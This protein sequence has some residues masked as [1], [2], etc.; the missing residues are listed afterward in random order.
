MQ[1]WKAIPE[2]EG[3]YEV[4]NLGQV[5]SLHRMHSSP[6]GLIL[7]QTAD[8]KGYLFVTLC[9]DG[10]SR[11]QAVHRLVL[12]AFQGEPKPGQETRHLNG[13]PKDNR[14][15]NLAWGSR[16]ENRADTT[17][18]GRDPHAN[19]TRC[20][21]GHLLFPENTVRKRPPGWRSCLACNRAAGYAHKRKIPLTKDLADS[22]YHQILEANPTALGRFFVAQNE[23]TTP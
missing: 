20:I 12:L 8:R 3:F 2:F 4:S 9:L 16:K 19:K 6:E 11:T 14:L 1:H 22:Y 18:H 15:E 10:T 13:D 7:K 17:K 23:R 5:R 21:R